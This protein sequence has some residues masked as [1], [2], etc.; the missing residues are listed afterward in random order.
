MKSLA[1]EGAQ[2]VRISVILGHPDRG[3]FNPGVAYEFAEGD[4]GE[5][6]PVG[7]LKVRTAL[8]FNTS[9]TP[10]EREL[11]VFGDPLETLW[12][13]CIFDLCGVENFYRKMYGVVVTSTPEQR[14]IW[15]A[16]VRETVDRYF[17]KLATTETISL[18]T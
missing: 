2:P 13:N 15:L 1:F 8:V 16:D 7:L 4:S 9:N 10:R 5:G 18:T 3:S 17:P 11:E 12:K 6:V 14:R